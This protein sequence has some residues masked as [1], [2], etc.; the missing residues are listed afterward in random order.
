MKRY[1]DFQRRYMTFRANNAGQF[2]ASVNLMVRNMT[3]AF[4]SKLVRVAFTC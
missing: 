2:I 4:I 1:H 3:M